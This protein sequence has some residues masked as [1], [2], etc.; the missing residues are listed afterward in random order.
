MAQRLLGSGAAMTACKLNRLQ[1]WARQA[2]RASKEIRLPG[3]NR[4]TVLDSAHQS[5]VTL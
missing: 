5:R 3:D 4:A 2:V 1:N